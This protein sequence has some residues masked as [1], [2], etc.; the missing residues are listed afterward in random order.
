VIKKCEPIIEHNYNRLMEI[1]NE[2]WPK[3]FTMLE[4][5]QF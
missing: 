1:V 5:A 4:I 2:P 3:S